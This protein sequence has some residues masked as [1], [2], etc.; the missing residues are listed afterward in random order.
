MLTTSHTLVGEA[1]IAALIRAYLAADYRWELDGVWRNLRIGQPAP[2]VERWCPKAERFGLLSAW[3]PY[4]IPRTEDVNRAAD[5]NLHRDLMLTGLSMRAA[6]SSA[7]NR[8]WRE[9]SWLVAGMAM[10]DFDALSW[11]YGQLATLAWEQ[12][13]PVRLRVDAARPPGFDDHP[14]VDWLK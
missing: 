4:S 2:E 14:W 1:R 10:R 12:G 7:A 9:P 6:F 3:D 13:R 5:E 8:S 11:S